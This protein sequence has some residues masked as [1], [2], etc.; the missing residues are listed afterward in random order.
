[1]RVYHSVLAAFVL[2]S[3]PALAATGRTKANQP[4]ASSQSADSASS[5]NHK[6]C[7]DSDGTATDTRIHSRECKTKAEWAKRGVDID[8]LTKQQ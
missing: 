3:A 7:V 4:P 6:Y 5:P 1:M 8:E 2:L